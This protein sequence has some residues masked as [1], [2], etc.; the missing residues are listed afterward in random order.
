MYFVSAVLL[1]HSA[2]R[3]RQAQ[4]KC[5]LRTVSFP[6]VSTSRSRASS[7][8]FLS[9]YFTSE[10][11]KCESAKTLNH[12]EQSFVAQRFK[13]VDKLHF[14][15]DYSLTYSR[16]LIT[17]HRASKTFVFCMTCHNQFSVNTSPRL[18]ASYQKMRLNAFILSQ[19]VSHFALAPMGTRT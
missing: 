1:R 19:S 4:R 5:Q 2:N 14:H 12:A 16:L 17:L 10:C 13:A 7:L 3:K 9:F 8:L 15:F 11:S 6:Q 18:G